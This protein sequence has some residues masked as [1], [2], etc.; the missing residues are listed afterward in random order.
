MTR[1]QA[2]NELFV[3][4][5]FLASVFAVV[6]VVSAAGTSVRGPLI[7]FGMA[8]YAFSIFCGAVFLGLTKHP[9]AALYCA[10]APVVAFLSIISNEVRPDLATVDKYVLLV[11]TLLWAGYA[12]RVVAI[13][14]AF[15][16]MPGAR[17]SSEV[18]HRG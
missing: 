17:E 6:T 16:R 7:S 9:R 14:K 2:R 5:L 3:Y 15:P 4:T 13:A 8:A 18:R 10:T 11:V 12:V 1:V